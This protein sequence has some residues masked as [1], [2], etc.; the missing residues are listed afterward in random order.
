VLQS[1][2]VSVQPKSRVTCPPSWP[3]RSTARTPGMSSGGS[4]H[5]CMGI[6]PPSGV[7]RVWQ[8]PCRQ[9]VR[10]SPARS[11]PMVAGFIWRRSRRVSSS[12][13]RCPWAVR[14]STKSSMPPAV[15]GRFTEIVQHHRLLGLSCLQICLCLDHR[16]LLAFLEPPLRV[17]PSD[18]TAPLRSTPRIGRTYSGALRE[19]A[20]GTTSS[21]GLD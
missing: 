11:L 8:I 3:T 10:R 20:R 17:R 7:L 13:W 12:A 6:L 9:Y 14:F 18:T 1:V 19:G 21:G 5:V 16:E 2:T 4:M 15:P